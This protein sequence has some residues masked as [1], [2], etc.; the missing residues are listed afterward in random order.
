MVCCHSYYITP[1]LLWD[2]FSYME[3]IT[4]GQPM[5]IRHNK[6][7][8][9]CYLMELYN[10]SASK[11]STSVYF[12]CSKI[13]MKYS[14]I[15]QCFVFFRCLPQPYLFYHTTTVILTKRFKLFCVV[16]FYSIKRVIVILAK[17]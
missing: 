16:Q 6:S 2:K 1:M 14:A 3:R 12:D 9:F 5:N 17:L 13:E 7:R 4:A 10:F 8:F 15:C 11:S